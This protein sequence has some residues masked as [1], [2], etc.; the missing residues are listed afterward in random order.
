[1]KTLN[2]KTA[3]MTS[4]ILLVSAT[5]YGTTPIK[6]DSVKS[7]ETN[8]CLQVIGMAIDEK[9]EPLDDVS[10][11]LFQEN[12]EMEWIEVTCVG[13][14]DHNFVFNLKANEYYTIEISKSGYVTR[15]VAISTVLPENVEAKPMFK[16]G[17]DVVLFKEKK[18]VDDFYFD[19]PVALISYD[20]KHQIF[21][22][23]DSYTKHIKE[24]IKEA[25]FQAKN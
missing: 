15:S 4:I 9:N 7:I 25:E 3:I 22:N 18:G 5:I 8:E 11:K 23:H 2:Y 16:Y 12:E 24:K 17:F 6:K 20:A 19:F 21:E 10:V 13:Y 14:H 1:M